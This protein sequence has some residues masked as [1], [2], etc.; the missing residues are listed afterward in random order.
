MFVPNDGNLYL[1][2]PAISQSHCK[3]ARL[4]SPC[5]HLR[6][7]TIA[8]CHP[9]MKFGVP[10]EGLEGK[11]RYDENF[12][13]KHGGKRPKRGDRVLVMTLLVAVVTD[14][15]ELREPGGSR[16]MGRRGRK[17]TAKDINF[18]KGKHDTGAMIR[19][20]WTINVILLL[21]FLKRRA[22]TKEDSAQTGPHR[23]TFGRI[24]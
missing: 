15:E 14:Y 1:K 10:D 13:G 21:L 4:G 8:V 19:H 6:S 5:A 16:P 12:D 3:Y 11:I 17:K 24:M 2:N 23:A 22:T 20:P 7:F 18:Q 9:S